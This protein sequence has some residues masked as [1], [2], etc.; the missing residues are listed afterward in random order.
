M[1]QITEWDSEKGLKFLIST[2]GHVT[3]K[4]IAFAVR[5]AEIRKRYLCLELKQ[6][7]KPYVYA[8]SRDAADRMA[9]EIK[10]CSDLRVRPNGAYVDVLAP[11][12]MS[13]RHIA[14][15]LSHVGLGDVIVLDD[16]AYEQLKDSG[17]N[18]IVVQGAEGQDRIIEVAYLADFLSSFGRAHNTNPNA[19][20]S[21]LTPEELV[22]TV[23]AAMCRTAEVDRG[24]V[25][26]LIENFTLP[27]LRRVMK[28][29]GLK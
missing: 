13:L 29:A 27:N 9:A 19:T 6:G 15:Q 7:G 10:R 2:K 8:G 22:I 17:N 28:A 20:Y 3:I 18:Y 16:A 4:P 1:I 5:L 23:I 25:R 26:R 21:P 24:R 14:E 12:Q 11:R